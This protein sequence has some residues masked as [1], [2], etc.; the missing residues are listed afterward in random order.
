MTSAAR[1]KAERTRARNLLV[2]FQRMT[3]DKNYRAADRLTTWSNSSPHSEVRLAALHAIDALHGLLKGEP[4]VERIDKVRELLSTVQT[5]ATNA[6]PTK[7]SKNG[8]H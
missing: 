7:N 2:Y 6:T 8:V 1:E 4:T 5:A 3:R